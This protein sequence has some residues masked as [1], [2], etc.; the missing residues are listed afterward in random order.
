MH[1]SPLGSNAFLLQRIPLFTFCSSG[2]PSKGWRSR[3][4]KRIHNPNTEFRSLTCCTPGSPSQPCRAAAKSEQN[5]KLNLNA[6]QLLLPLTKRL[7]SSE[8]AR[9]LGSRRGKEQKQ[10]S[11][12]ST[13]W[14]GPLPNTMAED[15]TQLSPPSINA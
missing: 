8:T 1:I 14:T 15:S 13:N 5:Q 7:I 10:A 6:F 12:Q 2:L 11:R 3:S 4:V 9:R